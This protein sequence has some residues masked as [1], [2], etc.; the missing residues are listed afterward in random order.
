M[1]GYDPHSSQGQDQPRPAGTQPAGPVRRR[2]LRRSARASVFVVIALAF[3]IGGLG[4]GV[5]ALT[6]IPLRLPA[7]IVTRVEARL[8]AAL[9]LRE[10]SLTIGGIEVMVDRGFVPRLRME[11]LSLNTRSGGSLLRLPEARLSFD[12]AGLLGAQIR[13][14]S[15]VIS[16]AALRLRRDAGGRFDLDLG[17][18][19]ALRDLGSLPEA[20]DRLDAVFAEPALSALDQVTIESLSLTLT[21]ERAGRRFTIGDG[22][23]VLNNTADEVRARLSFSLNSDGIG[24]RGDA[25]DRLAE[26][27]PPARAMLSL[28][29]RKD[30]SGARLRAEVERIEARDLAASAPVLGFFE[31]LEA[32]I[33][34]RLITGLTP[35]GRLA[36]VEGQLSLGAG[37]LQPSA[38]ARPIAFEG[39]DLVFGFDPLRERIRLTQLSV[40]S[41]TLRLSASGHVDAPGAARGFDSGLNAGLPEAFLAQIAISQLAVDPEGLFTRPVQFDAGALDLRLRLDPFRVEVGQF[42]LADQGRRISA[43]GRARADAAGWR[44]AADIALDRI[45]H[46]RLLALWPLSA[47]PR[48]REWLVENVLEGELRDVKIALRLE[49]G[50]EPRFALNYD[51]SGGD[52]RFIKT[53]PPIRQASGYATI[54]GQTYTMVIDSGIVSPPEGGDIDVAGSVFSVLDI[55]HK[56]AQAEVRLRTKSS[57]TAALSL[58][59]EPPFQFLTKAGRPVGLGDGRAA[60]EAL[61]RLSL[62]RRVKAEDVSYRVAAKLSDVRSEVLVPDRVLSA[63]ALDLTA[64]PEGLELTGQADLDKVPF[65]ARFWLPFAK[66]EKGRAEVTGSA[67]LSPAAAKIFRLGLPEGM[68]SGLGRGTFRLD[69]PKGA[70][71]L[72]ELRSD[73]KGLGLALPD[74]AWSKPAATAGKLE[75]SARLGKPVAVDRL[76]IEA[77][78]LSLR[79]KVSLKPDGQLDRLSLPQVRLGQ[80]FTGPA[81]LVGR[82]RGVP[83]AVEVPGGQLDLRHLPDFTAKGRG[84]PAEGNTPVAVRLDRVQVNET[85]ALHDLRGDFSTR[86]GLNGPFTASVNG[87]AAI[88]GALSPSGAGTAVRVTSQDAGGVLAAAGVF[89]KARGGV[90]DLQLTPEGRRGYYAGHALARDM[91]VYDAP[92]LAGLLSAISV[93]GILDQLRGAGLVFSESEARFRLTPAGVEVQHSA[94]VGLS[95]GVTLAGVYLSG[96]KRL[97]MQG[98]ISPVYLLNG[99]GQLVSKPGEG[100]FGFNYR[101]RGTA[102]RPEISVNPL[103]ILT[104]GMFRDLFRRPPPRFEPTPEPG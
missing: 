14:A 88:R 10:T 41:R 73:L 66:S 98:V 84:G 28:A 23:L 81:E 18:G 54:E 92:V 26:G 85:L 63:R 47:V 3:L 40:Q 86:G 103:S 31:A 78:G 58:L 2:L 67:E 69:L 43:S 59:D 49:Q 104:P 12:A 90:L 55:L 1:A 4:V 52:A 9:P 64:T 91:R 27:A 80:W 99:V 5:L 38:E 94:A 22:H 57:L 39:A 71:A 32:P 6:G 70:P 96:P 30:S 61:L 33:S 102:D 77:P 50:R 16:G 24:G 87:R 83:P 101:L 95:M 89:P 48:T 46:D 74:L 21:D 42:T 37:A 93:V 8:N 56:P 7:Q 11:N 68:L 29:S 79:G 45:G 97:D 36:V 19:T 25:M 20:I 13:P 53:L 51:F 34:G 17:S 100:L 35:E 62:V 65:D 44:L 76:M 60:V 72:L 82:G 75:V 15:V